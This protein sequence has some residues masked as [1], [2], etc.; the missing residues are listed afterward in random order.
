LGNITL[1]EA[2]REYLEKECPYLSKA[3]LG[4][5]SRFHLRPKEQLDVTF[6]PTENDRDIGEVLI[7]IHGKWVDT[8]LY[9]IPLLAL[10]SEAYFKFCDKD[11]NHDGQEEKAYQKGVQLLQGGCVFSEF[12]SRRRRD[13]GTHDLVM[14]GLCRAWKEGQEKGWPGKF[15][16]TSN[17]HFAHK[18]GVAPIGTVAHE[19]Y[20]GIAAITDNYEDASELGLRYWVG[21]FGEGV[22]GIALTDTFGTPAFLKAFNRP[23]PAF[24]SSNGMQAATPSSVG[25][26][27]QTTDR[28]AGTTPP[29]PTAPIG[30][31]S[32]PSDKTYAQVFAGVRQDSGDPKDY[33]KMLR[34][35]YHSIGIKEKKQLVFS[36]SLNIER[37]FEYKKISE[38]A[39]FAPSFGI[40]TFMTSTY[41][42][43]DAFCI[44]RALL[45]SC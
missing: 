27:T 43:L 45:T 3:Y 37:C 40:G 30:V 17:V 29:P 22:L 13:Y 23:V 8:I 36:D 38:E 44:H 2:E 34:D 5:L 19:W 20:M 14:Q 28:L 7:T 31:N 32:G 39:G 42:P 16:G 10:T 9:E 15:L 33:V 25:V 21:T 11:W 26:A 41:H 18:Y 6:V 4:F 1:S 24:T 12:G 35:F